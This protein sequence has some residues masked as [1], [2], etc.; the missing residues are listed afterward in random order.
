MKQ[1]IEGV[2]IGGLVTPFWAFAV[3]TIS[4]WLIEIFH[5]SIHDSLNKVICVA[6]VILSIYLGY[7]SGLSLFGEEVKTLKT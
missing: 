4:K 7:L 2:I 5:I 1:T 6:F 3:F